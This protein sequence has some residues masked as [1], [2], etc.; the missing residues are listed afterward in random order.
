MSGGLWDT[1]C[2]VD[3]YPAPA[4]VLAEARKASVGIVAVTGDPGAYRILR[5]RVGRRSDVKVALGLHPLNVSS[6]WPTDLAR[7]LRLLPGASWIGEVGLDFSAVGKATRRDQAHVF[8]ALLSEAQ[9]RSRIMTV[10]SR[11]AGREVIDALVDAR[12]RAVL[13]WYTGPL[14]AAEKAVAQGLWFSVNPAMIASTKAAKLLGT[15]V[16]PERWLLE[17]DG[18][19]VRDCGRPA[20]PANIVQLVERLGRLWG[21]TTAEAA[22]VVIANQARLEAGS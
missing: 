13:H 19:Y 8:D 9:V 6:N 16:P 11:G 20:R 15:V 4:E 18:P 3:A 12:V 2:H 14:S 22:E 7:F 10:H 17:T 1:H 5:T 21:M